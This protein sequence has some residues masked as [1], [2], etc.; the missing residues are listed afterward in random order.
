MIYIKCK[1]EMKAG[2]YFGFT[3]LHSKELEERD[4]RQG[5]SPGCWIP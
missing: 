5:R 4:H 2:F 3:L 1:I